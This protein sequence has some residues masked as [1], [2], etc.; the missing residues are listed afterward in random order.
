MLSLENFTVL[1]KPQNLKDEF[2]KIKQIY[3]N[4]EFESVISLSD[5]MN[6]ILLSQLTDPAIK[7]MDNFIEH[8]E[9]SKPNVLFVSELMLKIDRWKNICSLFKNKMEL[10]QEILNLKQIMAKMSYI[11][12]CCIKRFK[13]FQT[14]I[15]NK[16]I[17]KKKNY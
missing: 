13:H 17:E 10:K 3:K 15:L 14:N 4:E 5:E 7:D 2:N 16:K 6:K 12:F 1:P 11:S 9:A 8:L